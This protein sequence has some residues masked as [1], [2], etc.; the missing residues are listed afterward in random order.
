MSKLT[1]NINKIKSDIEK[2][3]K[4]LEEKQILKEYR[5]YAFCG[6]CI[7]TKRAPL[8]DY[9]NKKNEVN[10][11]D[12]IENFTFKLVDNSVIYFK[13]DLGAKGEL[14]KGCIAYI[15][16]S[17]NDIDYN[18]FVDELNEEQ[19]ETY[20]ELRGED[21]QD[22]LIKNHI[23][24]QGTDENIVDN[25]LKLNRN[26]IVIR[27]DIDEESSS[28]A[29]PITHLTINNI[30][31]SRFKINKKVFVSD[32]ISFIMDLIYGIKNKKRDDVLNIGTCEM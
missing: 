12:N 14:L 32:F 27:V 28:D 13:M 20:C 18:S 22:F 19:E 25:I 8:S 5:E 26:M 16:G 24:K 30:K 1:K 23:C 9:S 6:N 17:F 29:H 15:S 31:N 11:D 4:I 2:A 3:K 10:R 7:F 21:V